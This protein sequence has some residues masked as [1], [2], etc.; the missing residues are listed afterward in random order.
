[1]SDQHT[2][3]PRWRE[4]FRGPRGRMVTGLLMLEALVAIYALVV[5]AIMPAVRDDLGRTDLY[6]FAF[7]VWGLAT[8]LTIPIAGHAA[9]RFGPRRPLLIVLGVQICGLAVSGFAPSMQIV[10]AGLFLQGCAGG[11]LYAVSLGTVAKTFP[12]DVRARVMALLA[13]MWILPG[14]VGP[15]LGAIIAS[16]VG[17]RWAFALPVP[18]L[19]LAA[20]LVL[21]VLGDIEP[22]PQAASLPILRSVQVTLGLGLLLGG[23]TAAAPWNLL[24]AVVGLVIG[25]PGLLH[26]VPRGTFSARR[27]M[28]A[29]ALA[30]FLLS[31]AFF[32]VDSF[33][34]LM[35][36]EL[37]GF[38]YAKAS[39][40]ITVATVTW[41]LGSWWQSRV[42]RRVPSG[43]LVTIGGTFVLV[44]MAGVACGLFVA[45]PVWLTYVGWTMAGGGMGIAFPTIPLSVMSVT[46]EGKEA[47]QLSSTLLM[48]TLGMTVGA[49]LGGASIA[50]ATAATA[51][52]AGLRTGIAGAYAIGF[53]MMGVLLLIARRIPNAMKLPD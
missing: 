19:L 9:D 50:F 48:D 26:I 12:A 14:L 36:R 32:T 43:A 5:T 49:G 2:E 21:P 16:T 1:M 11:A 25:L 27:G 40:V 29:A 39:L 30:M 15:L 41:S 42:A 10:I 37:H 13:T 45:L 20:S 28:P 33:I 7:A 6:G 17:W 52:D 51:G 34:P 24:F 4:V 22:D 46:D 44:G 47:G 3:P 18:L 53:V 35:L 8:I 23:L 38:S 31:G